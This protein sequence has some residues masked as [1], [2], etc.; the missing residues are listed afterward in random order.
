MSSRS[1]RCSSSQYGNIS[2][3]TSDRQLVADARSRW[4]N[5]VAGLRDA[6]RVQAGVVGNIDTNPRRNGRAGRTEPGA[7]G[8]L[9]TTQTGNQLLALQSQQI[10]DLIA[11]VAANGPGRGVDGCGAMRRRRAGDAN[12]AAVS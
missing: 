1:T 10:A 9:Q 12:S 8:A 5:T 7:T 2:L 4:Q 3:S 6:M 11:V